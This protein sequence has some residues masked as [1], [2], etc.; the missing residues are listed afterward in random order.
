MSAEVG[1]PTQMSWRSWSNGGGTV[2]TKPALLLAAWSRFSH[3]SSVRCKARR[4]GMERAAITDALGLKF[5][6]SRTKPSAPPAAPYR[7]IATVAQLC[8]YRHA[9]LAMLDSSAEIGWAHSVHRVQFGSE[10]SDLR[11]RH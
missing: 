4:N 9:V 10:H 2:S 7:S 5:M 1:L 8:H 11:S 6:H 3:S